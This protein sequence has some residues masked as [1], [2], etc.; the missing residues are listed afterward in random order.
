VATSPVRFSRR[1]WRN[2]L[3]SATHGRA[4]RYPA[5]PANGRGPDSVHTPPHLFADRRYGRRWARLDTTD[6]RQGREARKHPRSTGVCCAWFPPAASPGRDGRSTA[7]TGENSRTRRVIPRLLACRS[8]SNLNSS[9]SRWQREP[10]HCSL[11]TRKRDRMPRDR[12]RVAPRRLEWRCGAASQSRRTYES[13]VSSGHVTRHRQPGQS[14]PHLRQPDPDGL[15]RETPPA[16]MRHVRNGRGGA[17]CGSSVGSSP[18]G[19]V[20]WRRPGVPAPF[21]TA[22]K[23]SFVSPNSGHGANADDI[24]SHFKAI[25]WQR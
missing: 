13:D 10:G 5:V 7:S 17:P 3:A 6:W 24:G 23:R 11:V 19:R 4:S 14:M 15:E 25:Q 1:E 8:P 9:G 16:Q 18:H 22:A 20:N 21:E 2:S 12:A